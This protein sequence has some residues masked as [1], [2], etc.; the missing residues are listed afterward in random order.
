MTEGM[1][2]RQTGRP[3]MRYSAPVGGIHVVDSGYRGRSHDTFMARVRAEHMA[4][5]ARELGGGYYG[6]RWRDQHT[7]A[8][9]RQHQAAVA[10]M[11]A[12]IRLRDRLPQPWGLLDLIARMPAPR[13]D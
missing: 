7:D 9:D 1:L 11:E 8:A 6:G 3:A 5:V 4:A 10:R 2:T 12:D 13:K